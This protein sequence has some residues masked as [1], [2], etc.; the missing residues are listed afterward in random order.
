[1]DRATKLEQL[2]THAWFGRVFKR[3]SK[4][5]LELARSFLQSHDDLAKAEFEFAVNRMFLDKP[6]PKH[7]VEILDLLA[8]ANVG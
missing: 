5:E 2:K 8:N 6:K 1:M 3:L 7:W 4:S